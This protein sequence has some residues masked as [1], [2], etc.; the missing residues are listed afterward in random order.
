[1]TTR[2]M[3]SQSA[4][5]KKLPFHPKALPGVRHQHLVNAFT[6]IDLDG[7]GYVGAA[8][9]RHLLTV[10]GETPLDEEID[11]MIRMVDL[12][13]IGQIGLEEW[14]HIYEQRAIINEMRNIKNASVKVKKELESLANAGVENIAAAILAQENRRKDV[15]ASRIARMEKEEKKD[16]E[17]N[18]SANDLIFVSNP[19]MPSSASIVLSIYLTGWSVLCQVSCGNSELLPAS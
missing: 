7:N 9:I 3:A 17:K 8:E 18:Y 2:N 15:S 4:D 1:M 13:G 14:M 6:S 16:I 11:E 10:L 19:F 5:S 12:D